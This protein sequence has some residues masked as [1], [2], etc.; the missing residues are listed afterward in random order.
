ML[1]T[2]WRHF[3]W[4][5]AVYRRGRDERFLY[6]SCSQDSWDCDDDPLVRELRAVLRKSLS[7]DDILLVPLAIGSHIDHRIVRHAA[8]QVSRSQLLYYPDIPYQ[9]RFP[10]EATLLATGLRPLRYAVS[11]LQADLWVQAVQA[12]RSQ[13]AMLEGAVGSLPSLIKEYAASGQMTLWGDAKFASPYERLAAAL[14]SAGSGG[15]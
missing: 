14:E 6:Q 11:E 7:M 5:D 15:L 12:Y 4:H 13:I 1:G 9:Q 10:D 3:R 8:E 2:L